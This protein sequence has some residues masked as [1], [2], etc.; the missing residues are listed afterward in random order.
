VSRRQPAAS[1]RETPTIDPDGDVR[2][3]VQRGDLREATQLLMQRHGTAV[4]RY[5][6][7]ELRDSVLADDVHQHVFIQVFRDLP[8]FGGASTIRVW[9]FAIARHR[10]LDAAKQRRR[11]LYH[12]A[13][14]PDV[15]APDPRPSPDES[16]DDARLRV[17]VHD[18]LDQL[19]TKARTAVIVHYQQGFT[20]EAM[21]GILGEK[22]GTIHA[23]VARALNQLRTLIARASTPPGKPAKLR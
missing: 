5:V 2:V 20:F 3:L 9:L 21:A 12:H 18:C 14:A 19:S 17:L 8:R 4:Y 13:D 6:R 1:R 10:V 7:A 11:R 16:I 22:P 23:R 15:D